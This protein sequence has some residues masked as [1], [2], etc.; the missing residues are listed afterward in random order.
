VVR[1]RLKQQAQSGGTAAL[2]QRLAVVDNMAARKIHPNDTY[3]IIRALEV[4]E[5]TGE[6]LTI[7]Q[8]RH[9]FREQRFKTLE[10]G[11]SWPRP[12]LYERINHRVETMMKQGFVDEVRWLLS[13]GYNGDLKSM[14]SLG[15]RHLTAFLR[16]EATLEDAVNTLK[17]DH[18]RY[19]KRQKTWFNANQSAHWIAPEQSEKAVDLIRAFFS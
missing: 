15:Y 6:P 5:V 11:L 16:G 18:R 12:A 8:Q 10:I 2:H 1:R 3:R 4:F 14:Q 19:A 13:K 17:R 9:Q 7:F